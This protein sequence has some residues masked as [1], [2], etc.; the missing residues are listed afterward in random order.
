[1]TK[2]L[3]RL[4]T[5]RLAETAFFAALTASAGFIRIPLVPVP[6]T[7]Q[8]FVVYLSGG[9]LGSRSGPASQI[10]FLI[11][12]LA[13]L[14]VFTGGGGISYAIHP[15]FGYLVSFPFGS[16]IVGR[17]GSRNSGYR[18]LGYALSAVTILAV[19]AAALYAN[20]RWIGGR[21]VSP[22]W[23]LTS[24]ILLFL[25]GEIMKAGAA[26]WLSGRVLRVMRHA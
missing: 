1:M 6:V 15:S 21:S 17:F 13:G 3:Q 12:G 4:Y 2:P 26:F 5:R 8:T 9:I 18:A 25:P 10:L 7:L 14:P 19:G 16:W 20:L 24:G 11:L 22:V 23:I